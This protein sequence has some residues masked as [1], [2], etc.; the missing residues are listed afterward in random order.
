MQRAHRLKSAG[1]RYTSRKQRISQLQRVED[2]QEKLTYSNETMQNVCSS[3]TSISIV[4]CFVYQYIT[5]KHATI[6]L[7][8]FICTKFMNGFGSFFAV[9]SFLLQDSPFLYLYTVRCQTIVVQ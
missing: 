5:N 9:V 4:A 1:L 3:A 7:E 6:A 2:K 8:T